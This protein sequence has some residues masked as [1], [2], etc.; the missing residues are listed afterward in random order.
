MFS[1]GLGLFQVLEWCQ[2]VLPALSCVRTY[3]DEPGGIALVYRSIDMCFLL[4]CAFKLPEW[5]QR[6]LPVLSGVCVACLM[7]RKM[8]SC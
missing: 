8:Y 2:R 5:S 3:I 6:V 1:E 4:V 7:M